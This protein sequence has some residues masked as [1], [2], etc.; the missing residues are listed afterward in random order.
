MRR[1]TITA[2]LSSALSLCSTAFAK[3]LKDLTP[4]DRL[5]RPRF[6]V[7]PRSIIEHT[8]RAT[9][10]THG[11]SRTFAKAGLNILEHARL[12]YWSCS[13]ACGHCVWLVTPGKLLPSLPQ[14]D[15]IHLQQLNQNLWRHLQG[16]NQC[17]PSDARDGGFLPNV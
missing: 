1:S 7:A 16:A 5:A 3:S 4:Q 13:W 17:S 8:H 11:L 14:P 2:I 6:S 12:L 15:L 9:H 10:D